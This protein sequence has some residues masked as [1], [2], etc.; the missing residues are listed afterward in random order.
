MKNNLILVLIILSL[1]GCSKTSLEEVSSAY[2][3]T[4]GRYEKLLKSKPT[5]LALRLKLAQFY[6]D[7]KDFQRVKELLSA[8]DDIA[9]RIILAKAL[10]QLKDYTHA[11]EIFEKLGEIDNN[12]YLYLYAKTLE[13]QNLFPKAVS[14]YKKVKPPFKELADERLKK[15]GTKVEEGMPENIKA[16][17][18]GEESFLSRIDKDEAVIL[19]VDEVIEIK[20]NN[21][22]VA[23]VYALKQVLKERGKDLAEVEL[24]YDSTDERVE[25]EYARTITPDGK[26]VYAGAENIRDVSKYLNFPLYSNA[27]VLIV[28]MPSVDIGSIIEYKAKIYSSKLINNENFS[29]VYHLREP[30]P[31]GKAN[32]KLVVPKKSNVK[33]KFFNEN[34]AKGINLAPTKEE[35]DTQTIYS[36]KFS[37][38]QPIIP[39]EGMPQLSYVNPAIGISNFNSWS[40][41]YKW[42]YGL[43]KDK[44][45]LSEEIKNFVKELIK[46][47]GSDLEKARRIYEFCA[48]NVRYVAVEYGQSGHEPHKADDI[49]LNRYGDCKDKAVLLVAMLREA[50]LSAY[51]VLI[52]T[53][54]IYPITEDFAEVAFNHAIAA[55]VYKDKVIFMDGTASTVSFGDIP[56]DDQERNVFIIFDDGYKILPTPATID[57]A[58]IYE[59]NIAI[60][61]NEDALI[62]RKITTT[63]F[64]ASAQR[65]YLKYTHPQAIEDNIKEK[66]VR[67]SPFSK[68]VDYRIEN[69]D[70]FTKTPLLRY[71]FQAKKFLNPA[72]NL[73]VIPLVDDI[74]I[75]TSYAGKEERNFPIDFGGIFGKISKTRIKLPAN[76][77]VK[78][79]PKNREFDT[80]W[81]NFKSSYAE[82]G[83]TIELC[84][85]FKAKKR[86]VEINEYKEFKKSLEEVFYLLKEEVILEKLQ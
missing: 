74:D 27:R 84:K 50:G 59:T 23:T 33:M 15:I 43:Y 69:V 85:E 45:A 82:I 22:S 21:T 55:L 54:G 57:N 35:S 71:S 8:N 26:V 53:R 75:D 49:F 40:D 37:E 58:A 42:W 77:K 4:S 73:R 29:F 66:M 20:D 1:S 78:F 41:A 46:G 63:G 14:V 32:F 7:F 38:V 52:P 44:I 13:A 36:W 65:Y 10:A 12:E 19:F 81:F 24:D 80:L 17:I 9:A 18:K 34:Y 5:D 25:L 3:E 48:Q 60:D 83:D 39:E 16:I 61:S 79:L 28:S 64:F 2:K 11:L 67:I 72:N 51:P 68:L 30:F 56:L 70:D 6:Y 47:A 31:V 86:F 62:E 76:L